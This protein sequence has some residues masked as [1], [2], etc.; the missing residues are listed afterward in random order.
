MDEAGVV[1]SAGDY[2]LGCVD[3]VDPF[4]NPADI[5]VV[6]FA[7]GS[8]EEDFGL[9][10]ELGS[11][12]AVNCTA[13]DPFGVTGDGGPSSAGG[14]RGDLLWGSGPGGGQVRNVVE[15]RCIGFDFSDCEGIA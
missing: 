14:E 1:A 2:S 10:A 11:E 4:A 9:G 3:L 13:T 5:D 12:S 6:G 7:I 15:A 8:G